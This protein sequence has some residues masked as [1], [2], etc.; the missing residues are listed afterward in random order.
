MPCQCY[1]T[2]SFGRSCEPHTG[3][4]R[5]RNGVIGRRCDACPNPY[6]EVTLRG[7][8][9]VYDGCPRSF[10]EG[11][12]W[13][14]TSFGKEAIE[15]CP[16]GSQGK[17]SRD[18]DETLGGWQP[19]DLFNCTGDRLVELRRLVMIVFFLLLTQ[20]FVNKYDF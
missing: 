16:T 10:S 11:L 13:P 1:N 2:G 19:P 9:V 17:A 3:Q 18:C 15:A 7:C 20:F 12:W 14:R 5:C 8:E 6:A 4:C